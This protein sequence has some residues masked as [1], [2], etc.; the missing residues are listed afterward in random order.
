MR[1]LL[2]SILLVM[3]SPLAAAQTCPAP[4]TLTFQAENMI[5]RDTPG[6]TE[7]L[8]VHDGAI[9]ESTGNFFGDSRIDHADGTTLRLPH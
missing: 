6:F 4:K 8:E 2:F 1:S 3:P 9:Y 7:G 5:R